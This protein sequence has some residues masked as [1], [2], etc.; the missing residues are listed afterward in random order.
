MHAYG[1]NPLMTFYRKNTKHIRHTRKST[2]F[3]SMATAQYL[4]QKTSRLHSTIKKQ[5]HHILSVCIRYVPPQS[6][7]QTR[8]YRDFKAVTQT[9][10][11][12]FLEGCDWSP[13]EREDN[14]DIEEAVSKLGNNIIN[15]I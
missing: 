5:W 15:A 4:K 14:F 1:S 6:K 12:D 2:R 11:L 3:L 10:V 9:T 13:F 7:D 8:T